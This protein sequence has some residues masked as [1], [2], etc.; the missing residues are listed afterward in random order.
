MTN[1]PTQTQTADDE[2]S[3]TIEDPGDTEAVLLE[4]GVVEPCDEDDLCV[5]DDLDAEWREQMDALREGD[6][7]AQLTSFFGFDDED[8]DVEIDV[9]IEMTEEGYVFVRANNRLAARWESD[10]AALADLAGAEVLSEW[11]PGW[12]RLSLE[13]KSQLTNGLRAFVE[14]CPTCGGDISLSEET[15]ESCCRTRETYAIFCD[16]CDSRLIEVNK[17]SRKEKNAPE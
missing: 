6:R 17:L 3:V 8:L 5:T 11:L 9:T 4:Y 1:E 7:A 13:E 16:D 14:A 12:D 2:D 10:A 15:V